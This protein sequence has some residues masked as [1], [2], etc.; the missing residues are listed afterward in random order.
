MMFKIGSNLRDGI[1]QTAIEEAP[2]IRKENENALERQQE[3]RKEKEKEEYNKKMRKCA[4][5]SW[6]YQS[7]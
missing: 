5:Y 4:T 1:I 7:V 3:R 6:D 2:H